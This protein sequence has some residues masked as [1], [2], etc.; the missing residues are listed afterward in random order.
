MKKAAQYRQE[1]KSS[2][3]PKCPFRIYQEINP[4]EVDEGEG[5][6]VPTAG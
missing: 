1:G 4:S 5:G 3:L 6:V 2:V